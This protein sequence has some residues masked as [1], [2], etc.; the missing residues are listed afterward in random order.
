MHSKHLNFKQELI[1][2]LRRV[3][4][5]FLPLAILLTLSSYIVYHAYSDGDNAANR[6]NESNLVQL[7]ARNIDAD[8]AEIICDLMFL[9]SQQEAQVLFKENGD[10]EPWMQAH[11]SELFLTFSK[12]RKTYDQVRVLDAQGQETIR[13]NYNQG[14]P[15]IVPSEKL[16]NKKGRYYFEDA[17]AL[18]RGQVLVSPLDLNVEQGQ[19]E[20]PIKPMIRFGTPIFDDQGKKRGIV[21]LNYFGDHLIQRF[22]EI[23]PE[24]SLAQS[25]LLNSDSYWLHSPQP[26]T[27]W[28]FMYPEKAEVTFQTDFPLEWEKI[29]NSVEGQ[30]QTA[31]GLFTFQTVFPLKKGELSS[32]Y[33]WKVVSYIPCQVLDAKNKTLALWIKLILGFLMVILMVTS[34]KIAAA[35]ES[36]RMALERAEMANRTKS[37]FLSNMSHEIRTPMNGIMGM[38]ELALD[39]LHHSGARDYLTTAKSSADS[40]LR[41]L[42]DILD[43][44]KM[45]AG[46]LSIEKMEYSLR[47]LLNETAALMRPQAENNSIG[48][49]VIFL[50]PV[51]AS[52]FSDATRL[53]QCLLNLLGNA[54]KF[55]KQ[56]HVHLRVSALNSE[57][58]DLLRFE[59]LD[60]GVGISQE[61]VGRIFDTFEQEDTST[62]R[63]FGGTGLGLSI[64]R[65]L[66]ALLGG[67]VRAESV[68][69]QG[70]TFT[71]EIPVGISL[72]ERE[73][74]SS[75]DH[76]Q[77]AAPTGKKTLR[78]FHGNVLVAEDNLVNQKLIMALLKNLGLEI[79]LVVNG[80]EAVDIAEQNVYDLIF[81]DIQMPVMNGHQ[82]TTI[83]RDRNYPSPI[84]ALTANVMDSEIEEC[85]EAGCSD[86]LGKPIIRTDLLGVL[87]KYL[88]SAEDPPDGAA[89]LEEVPAPS[90]V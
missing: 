84:I 6:S 1:P 14:R 31:K 80:Q 62:T 49:E 2:M 3:A 69:G 52:F 37:Q 17:M 40:L 74:I 46:K 51:P 27:R 55:T 90:L 4:Q 68:P 50:T 66:T 42:N 43:L 33:S 76:F 13:V 48:F 75:L 59:V 82:A 12:S 32:L 64:T 18:C 58:E 11:L 86:F 88:A 23:R 81:M 78:K 73:L 63:R 8:I 56:G 77:S 7:Q 28:G 15:T 36:N 53:K 54:I 35:A 24:N 25:M 29:R 71:L 26:E 60:T 21:L 65:E 10:T 16:Q 67:W 20:Q 34:W 30:F 87:D 44:S 57:G 72:K 22:A 47:Q 89:P 83:L 85:F 19:V 9:A 38:I 70:S 5:V 61:N 45:D 39:D 41:I 79:T